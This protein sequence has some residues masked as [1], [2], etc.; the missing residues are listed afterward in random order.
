MGL[1]F[2]LLALNGLQHPDARLALFAAIA[3]A[4][5]GL[6]IRQERRCPDPIIDLRP[7]AR[8]GFAAVNLAHA[9]VN[10]AGFSL[11]LLLPFHLTGML[12]LPVPRAGLVLTVSP[13]GIILAGPLGGWL[14]TR[15]GPQPVARLGLLA[16]ALGLAGI[17]A[18]GPDIA[19]L[20][21]AMFVQG[22][23]LGL[24]QLAYFDIVTATLPR[25]DRGV[26]G[27]LGMATRTIGT[28]MG[29]TV[30]M[31]VFETLRDGEGSFTAALHGTFAFAAALPAALLLASFAQRR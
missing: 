9:L 25:E 11:M 29:A 30:L 23:G 17:A 12:A 8:P 4:A 26:A 16:S 7:F 15:H 24:F 6:F 19:M 3:A 13:L 27:A 10:L 1:V 5:L 28:V 18:G 22:F 20:A 31:L 21:A 14:A 2:L